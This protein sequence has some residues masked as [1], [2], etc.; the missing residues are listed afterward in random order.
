L[1][2]YG[3]DWTRENPGGTGAG[4]LALTILFPSA[5]KGIELAGWGHREALAAP[6]WAA[7]LPHQCEPVLPLPEAVA[8]S[9]MCTMSL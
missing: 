2:Y 7:I 6:G 8:G 1:G 3:H 4:V 9:A 5:V